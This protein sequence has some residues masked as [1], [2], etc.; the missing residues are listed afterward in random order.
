MASV[1]TPA[2]S[3]SRRLAIRLPQPLW[4]GLATLVVIIASLALQF[5]L[6]IYRQY[7]TIREVEALG[8]LVKTEPGRPQWLRGRLGDEWMQ[9]FDKATA[10]NLCG[11]SAD[12][13]TLATLQGL[14]SLR[15]LLLDG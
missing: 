1:P 9:P 8:G 10:V 3:E 2:P 13:R 7:V 6:P 11:T 14:T 5:G 15:V 4:L 12:D